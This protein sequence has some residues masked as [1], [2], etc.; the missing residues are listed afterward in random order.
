MVGKILTIQHALVKFVRLFHRQSFMLYGNGL[1]KSFEISYTFRVWICSG[2]CGY[3]LWECHTCPLF[4]GSLQLHIAI[5][6]YLKECV[7]ILKFGST[8]SCSLIK[9]TKLTKYKPITWH[10]CLLDYMKYST[11][12]SDLSPDGPLA[13]IM[14]C[15]MGE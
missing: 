1:I 2:C 11:L 13:V 10:T 14:R 6:L 12:D 4:G 7:I 9:E 8:V 15:S 5:F 3:I